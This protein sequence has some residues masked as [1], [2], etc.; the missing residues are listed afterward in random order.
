MANTYKNVNSTV[1]P[2]YGAIPTA[3]Y[4][5]TTNNTA[6]QFLTSIG[7]NGTSWTTPNENVMVVKNNPAELE[8]KGRMILNGQDLEERLKTIPE[9]T[10]LSS[11]LSEDDE[12]V[13]V[14]GTQSY[15]LKSMSRND[16]SIVASAAVSRSATTGFL[17]ILNFFMISCILLYCTLLYNLSS[18]SLF[19]FYTSGE[20]GGGCIKLN[21]NIDDIWNA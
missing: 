3:G 19:Q 18:N 8:V 21:D 17:T 10:E 14:S 15:T 12:C 2:G 7:S 4:V 11:A 20:E 5:Y 9:A 6:G 16:G 1:S 13:F